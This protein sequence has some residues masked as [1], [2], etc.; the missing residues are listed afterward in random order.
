MD[1][2]QQTVDLGGI[3]SELVYAP[4]YSFTD[5][6][7]TERQASAAV[8]SNL[9]SLPN[10][11]TRRLRWNPAEPDILRNDDVWSLYGIAA[12]TAAPGLFFVLVLWLI[13]RFVR[14]LMRRAA[15]A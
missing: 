4:V 15:S 9:S 5:A 11:T 6:E 2:K 13:G 10:G 14:R 3:R 8:A 12:L 7:G 1:E